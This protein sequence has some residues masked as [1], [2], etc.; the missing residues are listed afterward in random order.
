MPF[1][2]GSAERYKFGGAPTFFPGI[3]MKQGDKM[4]SP[5]LRSGISV[6]LPL[7]YR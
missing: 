6:E 7:S 2:R 5:V 3:A 4:L 1:S